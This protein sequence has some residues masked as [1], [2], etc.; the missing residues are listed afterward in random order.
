MQ[1]VVVPIVREGGLG[2]AAAVIRSGGLES[3]N[4]ANLQRS[5]CPEPQ[6][7]LQVIVAIGKK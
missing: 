5:A 2:I 4:G 7:L 6:S 3:A 1:P